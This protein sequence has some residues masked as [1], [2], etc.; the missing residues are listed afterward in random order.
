MKLTCANRGQVVKEF[1]A[2]HNIQAAQKTKTVN[3]PS[4]LKLP[5]G[6]VSFPVHS[7]VAKVKES[8]KEEIERGTILLG[9]E[10]VPSPIQYLQI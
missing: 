7:T 9:K 3:R 1:L 4:K 8:L 5:G 2:E 6:E 10:V